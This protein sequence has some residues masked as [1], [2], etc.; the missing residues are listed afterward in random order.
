MYIDDFIIMRSYDTDLRTFIAL[1]CSMFHC[2]NL[3]LLSY[4]LG[5]KTVATK[6]HEFHI[7]QK[8]SLDLLKRNGFAES[9]PVDTPMASGKNLFKNDSGAMDDPTFY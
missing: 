8:Y 4:F 5:L 6:N 9:K 7:S 3:G 2:H 1:V